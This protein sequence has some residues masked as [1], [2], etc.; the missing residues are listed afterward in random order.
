M[1]DMKAETCVETFLN[2]CISRFGDP[3][4][5][6][7]DRGPQFESELFQAFT[8]HLG[9]QRIRST[10]YHPASNG[11]VEREPSRLPGKFFRTSKSTPAIPRSL[12]DLKNQSLQP[13]PA[14]SHAKIK[15]FIHKDLPTTTH[16]FFRRNIVRRPLEQSYDGPYRVLSRTDKV[17]T[18]DMRGRKRIVSVDRLKPDYILGNTMQLEDDPSST[19]PQYVTRSG[20]IVRFRIDPT[21]IS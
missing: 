5:V 21:V 16:V 11:M 20:R 2:G 14:S 1:T 18:L 9:S 13:V 6:I 10:S 19:P 4:V 17:F 3:E 12:Q 8:K 7:T 15:A